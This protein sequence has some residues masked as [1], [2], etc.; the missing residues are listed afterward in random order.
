MPETKTIYVVWTNTDCTE[1]RG[2]QIPI[3]YADSLTTAQRLAEKRGVQG[4]NAAVHEF[5]AIKHG[6]N[7]CA[8]VVIEQPTPADEKADE[9]RAKK[10]AALEKAKALGLTEAELAALRLP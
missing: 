4:S 7:W 2:R 9:A 6:G 3:A 10:R 5:E 1:G 8:P